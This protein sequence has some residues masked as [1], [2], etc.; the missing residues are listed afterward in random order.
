MTWDN[1]FDMFWDRFLGDQEATEGAYPVDIHEDEQHV[2]VEAELPGFTKDQ[3]NVTLENGVLQ[4]AAERKAET[5]GQ[6]HLNE[7]RITKVTRRFSIPNTVDDQKV[8]AR[9]DSGVLHLTLQKRDE[10]LPRRIE[11]K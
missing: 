2:Y 7:R 11:V 8:Q 6:T 4:I 10:V 9:L 1:P 5:H 3:I